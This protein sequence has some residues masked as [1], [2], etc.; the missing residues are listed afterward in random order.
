M[1]SA[2]FFQL[3]SFAIVCLMLFG[4]K[5]VKDGLK[6]KHIQIMSAAMIW[7]ILLILQIELSRSAVATAAQ[8]VGNS[9]ILN[10]HIA[11]AVS[12]VLLYVLML[13]SGLKLLG[14]I[15]FPQQKTTAQMIPLHK[16]LGILTLVMRILTFATSFYAVA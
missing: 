7:D 15:Q 8:P 9:M 2:L 6:R 13:I 10:I 16:K 1:S 5:V 3:Q 11:I 14:K 12:S 4:V